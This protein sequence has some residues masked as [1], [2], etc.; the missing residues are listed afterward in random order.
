MRHTWLIGALVAL[1]G[2][3]LATAAPGEHAPYRYFAVIGG[4]CERLVLGGRDQSAGCRDELVNIDFG[5]GRVAFAFTSPSEHGAVVTTFLG[6]ASTQSDLR[7]YRLEVDS[8]STLSSKG[9]GTPTNVAEAAS[10]HCAMTGDPTKEPARFECTAERAAGSTS[11]TF[12]SVGPPTVYAGARG[13]PGAV[14]AD[15]PLAR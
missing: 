10:G 6:R 7:N 2:P 8:I 13:V 5:D 9:G 3:T 1:A 12:V 4:A 14:A 11:A 15:A